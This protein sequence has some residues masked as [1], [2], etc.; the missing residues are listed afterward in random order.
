M[1]EHDPT[2]WGIHAGRIGEADS[3]FLK[4]NV[5]AIGWDAVRNS[6]GIPGTHTAIPQGGTVMRYMFAI[7]STPVSSTIRGAPSLS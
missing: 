1:S 2:L 7:A 4:R 5:I 3:L 6:A